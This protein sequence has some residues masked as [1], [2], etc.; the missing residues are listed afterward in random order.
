MAWPTRG[1]LGRAQPEIMGTGSKDS[2]RGDVDGCWEAGANTRE[3]DHDGWEGVLSTTSLQTLD[4]TLLMD[5][6]G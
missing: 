1:D 2:Q 5:T 3:S 6:G 4:I